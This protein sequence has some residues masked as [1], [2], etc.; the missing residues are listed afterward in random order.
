MQRGFSLIETLVVLLIVGIVSTAGLSVLVLDRAEGVQG[1]ARQLVLRL[2]QAQAY[3]RESG[4]AV[5]WTADAQGY[6]FR[7]HAAAVATPG[8]QEGAARDRDRFAQLFPERRWSAQALRVRMEP[9]GPWLFV[10]EWLSAPRR[11]ELDDGRQVLHVRS[12]VNG[13]FAVQP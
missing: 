12:D 13:R 5:S 2:A 8:A 3:V 10:N 9:A 6:R 4:H 11:L 7:L 1:D